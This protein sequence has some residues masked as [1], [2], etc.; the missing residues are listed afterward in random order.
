MQR[1]ILCGTTAG[2]NSTPATDW[3]RT[4]T[5]KLVARGVQPEAI[6][7]PYLPS[8]TSYSQ[9]HADNEE[10]LK[11]DPETIIVICITPGVPK[12]DRM[13][14]K[15]GVSIDELTQEMFVAEA[16]SL[17]PVTMLEM[18][19]HLRADPERTAVFLD[20]DKFAQNGRPRKLLGMF[21]RKYAKP[22]Y[23]RA[24]FASMQLLEDWVVEQ[25]VGH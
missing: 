16:E 17:G 11:A 3:R 21:L 10:A 18:G 22:P 4:L 9:V 23:Q 8:G 14:R 15:L 24:P 6:I 19:E 13:A 12:P 1:V 5:E 2:T 20:I 25:L 7:N